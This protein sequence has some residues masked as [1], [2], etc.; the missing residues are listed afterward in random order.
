MKKYKIKDT[1][2]QRK[3][4]LKTMILFGIICSIV[5]STIGVAAIHISANEISFKSNHENWKVDNAQD[6]LN[7]LYNINSQLESIKVKGDATSEHVLEGKNVVVKGNDILGTMK[8]NDNLIVNA[9]HVSKNGANALITIPENGYYSTNTKI[10]FSLE[11]LREEL[12]TNLVFTKV[13]DSKSYCFPDDEPYLVVAHSVAAA[14]YGTGGCSYSSSLSVSGVEVT[15]IYDNKLGQSDSSSY[16]GACGGGASHTYIGLVINQKD[17]TIT[18]S[19]SAVYV[20]NYTVTI[21]KIG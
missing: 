3:V 21:Y 19:H 18:V 4:T 8:N 6:A 5:S 13:S 9:N 14:V 7:S 12:G 11:K 17:Q 10:S 15:S 1:F 2:H 16:N 20:G